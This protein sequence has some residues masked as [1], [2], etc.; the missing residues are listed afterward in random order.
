MK[1]NTQ[2]KATKTETRIDRWRKQAHIYLDWMDKIAK[3]G[4][5]FN[6]TRQ[7]ILADI[8]KAEGRTPVDTIVDYL[9]KT[10][11]DGQAVET[12]DIDV[13]TRR[14]AIDTYYERH[15]TTRQR[16]HHEREVVYFAVVSIADTVADYNSLE[17]AQRYALFSRYYR[18][19]DYNITNALHRAA[20]DALTLFAAVI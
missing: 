8:A 14:A 15:T 20:V 7:K 2:T 12:D 16:N 6:M 17:P 9:R 18:R 5:D 19:G 1:K 11:Q 3:Q 4:N 13:E 10:R